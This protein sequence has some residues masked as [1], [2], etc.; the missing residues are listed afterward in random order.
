MYNVAGGCVIKE[1]MGNSVEVLGLDKRH[2]GK[3]ERKG[4]ENIRNLVVVN[5]CKRLKFKLSFR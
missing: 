1:I 2:I 3:T 4:V 5:G